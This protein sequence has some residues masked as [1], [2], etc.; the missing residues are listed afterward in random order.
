MKKLHNVREPLPVGMRKRK[1]ENLTTSSWSS[2][3]RAVKG[4][5]TFLLKTGSNRALFAT[6]VQRSAAEEVSQLCYRIDLS[7]VLLICSILA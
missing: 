7:D 3:M 1:E 5:G 6:A 2:Q 4:T